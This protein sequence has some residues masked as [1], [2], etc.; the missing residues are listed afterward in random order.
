[1]LDEVRNGDRDVETICDKDDQVPGPYMST[2][3]RPEGTNR[4]SQH[5]DGSEPHEPVRLNLVSACFE[6][7]VCGVP[8]KVEQATGDL[9]YEST[10]KPAQCVSLVLAL[11][12]VIHLI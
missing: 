5:Q 10:P 8:P 2:N 4:S 11:S 12:Q 6:F 1:M 9:D 7:V 3:A